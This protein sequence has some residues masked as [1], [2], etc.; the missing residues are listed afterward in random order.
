MTTPEKEPPPLE[1]M[2]TTLN[3]MVPVLEKKSP[4]V[5]N[6]PTAH[7]KEVTVKSWAKIVI[8]RPTLSKHTFQFSEVNGSNS[9]MV[10]DAILE[11]APLWE[12]FLVG[13]FASIAPHIAKIHVIV[14]KIWP[15]GDKRVKIDVF[16][17][18]EKMVKFRIRELSVRTRVIRREMWN[19]ADVPMVVSKWSPKAEDAQ[20]KIK[21]MPMWVVIKNV[22]HSMYSWKGLGFLASIVGEPKR[23]HPDTELCKNFEEAKVFV[24]VDLAKDLPK[25]HNFCLKKDENI[26]VDFSYSWFS[27][28]CHTCDKW[29][30]LAD[31]CL[32]TPKQ[33]TILQRQCLNSK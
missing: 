10:P 4:E 11:D 7:E 17:V 14:N 27:P 23:L 19:I 6:L 5:V 20:P 31:V 8:N 16:A 25:T 32:A 33:V 30:H 2:E 24:E 15:F 21:T 1:T 3:S 28:R 9:V 12:D 18:S 29:G 26:T 22:P 13:L